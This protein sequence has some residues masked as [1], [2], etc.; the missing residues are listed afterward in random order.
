MEASLEPLIKIA[1]EKVL[2]QAVNLRK[3]ILG[4]PKGVVGVGDRQFQPVPGHPWIG[5][6][7]PVQYLQFGSLHPAGHS[8]IVDTASVCRLFATIIHMI[9][10]YPQREIQEFSIHGFHD[11]RWKSVLIPND[12][13]ST[14]QLATPALQNVTTL[15]LQFEMFTYSR[16]DT[17]VGIT[18]AIEKNPNLQVLKLRTGERSILVFERRSEY[19]APLLSLLGTD[20]PFRLRTLMLDGL[21]TSVTAPTLDRI[22]T[23]HASTLRRVVFAHLN[24]HLPN[25]LRAFSTALAKTKITYFA[26]SRFLLHERSFIVAGSIQYD[27]VPDEALE[28][29]DGLETIFMDKDE[30]YRD[31]V[32]VDWVYSHNATLVYDNRDGS[33]GEGWMRVK[34]LDM[35]RMVDD[36]ALRDGP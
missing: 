23:V 29:E 1:L 7:S 11:T 10:Q 30:D 21:V 32:N 2:I 16:Y 4:A 22:I 8:H 20:P 19:W 35:A 15:D 25:S 14:T 34:F 27:T 3:V 24:F 12:W 26:T 17:I 33:Q 28:W 9:Q 36:G 5:D 6:N 13:V 18:K 31:W